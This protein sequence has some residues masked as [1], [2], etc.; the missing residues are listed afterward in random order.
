MTYESRN[1]TGFCPYNVKVEFDYEKFGWVRSDGSEITDLAWWD[2]KFPKYN[3]VL[4]YHYG[5]RPSRPGV[6]MKT[7][8]SNTYP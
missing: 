4:T 7:D 2:E 5:E 1:H 8:F 6:E 3:D